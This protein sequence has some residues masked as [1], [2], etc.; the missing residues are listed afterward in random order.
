MN[1]TQPNYAYYT[2]GLLRILEKA[3]FDEKFAALTKWEDRRDYIDAK[4]A[5]AKAN[6][7]QYENDRL[8]LQDQIDKL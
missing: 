2:G 1:N 6:A 4:V 8:A 7:I 5:E 3:I